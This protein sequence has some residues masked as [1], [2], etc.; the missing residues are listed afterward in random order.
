MVGQVERQPVGVG[1]GFG[2][3]HPLAVDVDERLG[4]AHHERAQLQAE[5]V[6]V[7]ERQVVHARDAH[8][9]GLGVQAGR[10][11]ADR[12]DAPA[13]P[14]L[15]LQHERLVTLATQLERGHQAGD[16]AADDDH[17]LGWA[18][19]RLQALLGG[20]HNLVGDGRLR[21]GRRRPR[22]LGI[23]HAV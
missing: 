22:D 16:P 6:A 12:P 4:I 7:G 14:V 17:L 21:I 5:Q 15:C 20:R 1:V 8:G 2:D 19:S 11:V 10:E 18:R 13:D 23:G 3:R 9:A